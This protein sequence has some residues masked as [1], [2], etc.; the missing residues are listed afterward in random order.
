MEPGVEPVE[1]AVGNLWNTW[2]LIH[3]NSVPEKRNCIDTV[4]WGA[5]F[6]R[7]AAGP[8]KLPGMRSRAFKNSGRNGRACWKMP[9]GHS[10]Q[11]EEPNGPIKASHLPNKNSLHR[12]SGERMPALLP[13]RSSPMKIYETYP[14]KCYFPYANLEPTSSPGVVSWLIWA[15]SFLAAE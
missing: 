14:I 8:E 15:A 2:N 9:A 6:S 7:S 4:C 10:R 3:S 1:P 11:L 5:G 13:E 12:D